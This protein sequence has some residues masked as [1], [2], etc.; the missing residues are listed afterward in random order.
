M[1]APG[2]ATRISSS[3]V[4]MAWA[5]TARAAEAAD[6]SCRSGGLGCRLAQAASEQALDMFAGID[7]LGVGAPVDGHGEAFAAGVGHT[8]DHGLKVTCTVLGLLG[9]EC[10]G[11]VGAAE[12]VLVVVVGALEPGETGDVCV[13]GGL[14]QHE[15][16]AGGERLHLGE[17]EGLVADVVDIAVGQVAAGDPGR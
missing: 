12:S 11:L 5:V 10:G 17:G 14:L 13:D 4:V 1:C 8:T 15:G 6:L 9:A 16:V 3:I 7:P 2:M